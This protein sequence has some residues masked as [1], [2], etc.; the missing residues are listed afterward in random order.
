[1]CH[2]VARFFA[3]LAGVAIAT[4]WALAAPATTGIEV[5]QGGI[6]RGVIE[7]YTG[8]L[9]GAAN[10][11]Y[12]QPSGFP[13]HGPSAAAFEG[14]IFFYQGSDGLHFSV[15][16]NT[17]GIGNGTV[18]WNIG[19]TG[20]TTDP[21]VQFSDDPVPPETTPDV[22]EVSSNFFVGDWDYTGR[23]DGGVIGPLGGSNWSI[24][25][26]QLG[27]SSTNDRGINK[28]FAFDASGSSL[29]LAFTT[30]NS[31]R[32]EFRPFIVP[33]PRAIFLA[34][35]L[36]VGVMRWNEIRRRQ[37]ALGSGQ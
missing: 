31:G 15:I 4:S 23:V 30:L 13:I 37:A 11:N 28:L 36:L 10:Y 3:V 35:G 25:I 22:R 34:L 5:L 16:F 27:Y 14:R 12:V 21:S 33:E 19:V 18:D 32:I 1:M 6:S 24:T 8:S 29:P 17:E 26:D 2:L 20:S 7:P 9:T